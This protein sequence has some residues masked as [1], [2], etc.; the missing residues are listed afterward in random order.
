M[1]TK[2]EAFTNEAGPVVKLVKKVFDS[3]DKDRS[4]ALDAMELKEYIQKL[5]YSAS[6]VE[7]KT[8]EFLKADE[9]NDGV[10]SPTEFKAF[11]ACYF[12]D[13]DEEEDIIAAIEKT[14]FVSDYLARLCS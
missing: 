7:E 9:N 3:I 12:D 4:G 2:E 6:E 5:G 8:H 10:L 14:F 13:E 11:L 1:P